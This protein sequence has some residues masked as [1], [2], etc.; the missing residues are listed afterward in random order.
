LKYLK[1][2]L[3]TYNLFVSENNTD[4]LSKNLKLHTTVLSKF[5]KIDEVFDKNINLIENKDF[6]IEKYK[7]EIYNEYNYIYTFQIKDVD[8][9]L[10]FIILKEIKTIDKKLKNKKFVSVSFSLKNISDVDYDTPTELNNQYDV[11][12]YIIWLVNHFKDK[13]NEN[14]IFMFGDP[15]D[16]RKFN[17]YEYIILKCFK[18]YEIIKDY[19]SGFDNTDV[20]Y[21]L[22]NDKND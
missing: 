22:I 3:R 1:T 9:R 5:L 2:S 15:K 6:F 7:H 16:D 19:T 20:G 13:I 14:Y 10:D 12:N 21:Y 11:L 4:K 8:Y 17:I 18:D